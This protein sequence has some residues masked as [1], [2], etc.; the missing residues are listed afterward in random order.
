MIV[1]QADSIN[2]S[3][4]GRQLLK[5][6]S[7]S[8]H[9]GEKVGLVGVNGSGK[10]TLLKCLTGEMEVDSGFIHRSASTSLGYLE[11]LNI[12]VGNLSAWDYMMSGFA[13]VLEMR[14]RLT[15]LEE[16]MNQPGHQLE[17]VLDAYAKLREAY[18]RAGGYACEN[19]A[20]RVL[21]GMSF[22]ERHFQQA[23]DNFSG[24]QK[25]RLRLGRL[26]AGQPD[27][28]LLDEPTNHLDTS[29]VE[30]LEGYLSDFSGSL[31]LVSHDRL[32]LEKITTRIIELRNGRLYSYPGNY[33]SYLKQRSLED[34][35]WQRAYTR[36]QEYIKRTEDFIRRYRSGIKARQARG[37]EA[38]LS[39]L[40]KLEAP[41]Q[42]QT[43]NKWRL[44]AVPSCGEE[45][46][47]T[48][49]LSKSYEGKGLFNQAELQIRRGEK[50]ALIGPNG[51]GK[52]TLLRI[53]QGLESA[54]AGGV[55]MG[56]RVR[57]G[58]FSQE[59]EDLDPNRSILEEILFSFSLTIEQARNYLGSILFTGDQVYQ[60]V[61]SLSGG[62]RGRVALLKVLLQEANFLL[63]DEPTNHLDIQGRQAVEE[64]LA[65]YPGTILL[66]SH[67]RY[68]IDQ[69]CQRMVVF[70]DQ[71]LVSYL[72][73]YTYYRKRQELE[74][75]ANHLTPPPRPQPRTAAPRSLGKHSRRRLTEELD[76]RETQITHLE[77]AKK[78]WEEQFSNPDSFSDPAEAQ[79]AWSQYKQM[80]EEL[81]Q[82]YSEW[83]EIG[84]LLEAGDRDNS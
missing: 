11:Q 29:A 51:C 47:K 24:G 79:A 3:L 83:E 81:A 16:E 54:D 69:I 36:Q 40:E 44:P 66:V 18:E 10:S 62:E 61:G 20:R 73:N 55:Q 4:G 14:H 65:S 34:L 77:A 38:K 37:R 25:T 49:E 21:K 59:N 57:L 26:L 74:T 32:L 60:K 78:E 41:A 2:K 19:T 56:A 42:D 23:M 43:L 76:K 50:V 1:V 8:L 53:V 39:H 30:W 80:E 82:A 67:D 64:L 52:T 35:A 58:C 70:E 71:N 72:G 75:Q 6:V 22:H 9:K 28:L 15:V 27:C 84:S 7:F 46:L 45:V 17:R 5:E 48:T 68:F 63:L 31:L 33:S 13:E 12:D